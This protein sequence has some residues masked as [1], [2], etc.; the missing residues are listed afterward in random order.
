MKQEQ[1]RKPGPKLEGA[2]VYR[3][4]H[5]RTVWFIVGGD[6]LSSHICKICGE[7]FTPAQARYEKARAKEDESRLPKAA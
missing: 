5:C 4:P 6:A 7:T 3:C 1:L 2:P